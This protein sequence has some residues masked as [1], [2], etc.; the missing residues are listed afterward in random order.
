[1]TIIQPNKND[2]KLNF[3]ISFSISGL[4]VF[5]VW[6]IFLYNQMVNFRHEFSNLEKVVQQKEVE[7]AELKNNLFQTTD[8]RNLETLV[9]QKSLILDKKPEYVKAQSLSIR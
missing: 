5:A 6:G 3:L 1:M 9:N 4:V 2:N 7:N 8:T